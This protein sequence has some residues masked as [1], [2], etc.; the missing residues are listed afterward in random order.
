MHIPN[1]TSSLTCCKRKKD[2]KES[3]FFVDRNLDLGFRCCLFC[4]TFK[5]ILC[6]WAV[7]C[8]YTLTFE[9]AFLGQCSFVGANTYLKIYMS[10][11]TNGSQIIHST[12]RILLGLLRTLS[13]TLLRGVLKNSQNPIQIFFL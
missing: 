8:I 11:Y 9:I 13:I 7:K 5:Q 3:I 1:N 2:T 10:V 12:S 4:H 6:F